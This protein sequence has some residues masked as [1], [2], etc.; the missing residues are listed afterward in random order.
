MRFLAASDK[1]TAPMSPPLIEKLRTIVR[2]ELEA[3][4]DP[5]VDQKGEALEDPMLEAFRLMPPASGTRS[6]IARLRRRRKGPRLA[7]AP[8]KIHDLRPRK[9]DHPK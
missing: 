7:G 6:F 4:G 1:K 8:A 2:Q 5:F 3:M 9:K